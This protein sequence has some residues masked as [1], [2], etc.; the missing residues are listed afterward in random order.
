LSKLQREISILRLLKHRYITSLYDVFESKNHIYMVMELVDGGELFDHIIQ[1]KRF[2]R[3]DALRVFR[4]VAEATEYFHSHGI[5]HR[6]IKPENILV[7]SSGDIKIADFGFAIARKD[8]HLKTSCGSPHYACPE[9]CSSSTYD[10]TKAD[11]WSLGVLLYVLITGDFPFNDQNYGALFHRIQTGKYVIPSYVD[12][13]IADLITR[14]LTVDSDCRLSVRGIL[15]HSCMQPFGS[16]LPKFHGYYSSGTD[17]KERR[18]TNSCSEEVHI[19]N[20]SASTDLHNGVGNMRQK[21]KIHTTMALDENSKEGSCAKTPGEIPL[22]EDQLDPRVVQ[23]LVFLGWGD[24]SE[25]VIET[26]LGKRPEISNTIFA[27]HRVL[28]SNLSRM[29]GNGSKS[30]PA[31]KDTASKGNVG[32]QN[33]ISME[34]PSKMKDRRCEEMRKEV[35]AASACKTNN[36]QIRWRDSSSRGNTID[37]PSGTLNNDLMRGELVPPLASYSGNAKEQTQGDLPVQMNI[38]NSPSQVVDPDG[39]ASCT[40]Q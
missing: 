21:P 7:H 25:D 15:E 38:S 27:A 20:K 2:G 4:Q 3:Y 33:Y 10:G 9:V 12:Q 18:Y 24:T 34:P 11:S 37:T 23:E 29:K 35:E 14:L 8:G 40:I 39:K 13:D 22:T 19:K 26:L 30:K 32:G 31:V 28:T 16:A 17:S 6:D 5:V 36:N 1:Q